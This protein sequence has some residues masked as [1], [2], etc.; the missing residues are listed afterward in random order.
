VAGQ[1][2]AIVAARVLSTPQTDLVVAG[3]D[4]SVSTLI[5]ATH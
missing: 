2:A 5:N 4:G 1:P 3:E